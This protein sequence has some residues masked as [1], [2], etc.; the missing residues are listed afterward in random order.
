MFLDLENE[1]L[2]DDP[3]DI[4]DPTVAWSLNQKVEFF[5]PRFA[6]AAIPTCQQKGIIISCDIISEL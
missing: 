3:Y 1:L 6:A 2:Y 4:D 5:A